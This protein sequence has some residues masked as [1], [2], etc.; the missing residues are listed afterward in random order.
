MGQAPTPAQ[1]RS[2]RQASGLTQKASAQLIWATES[3]WQKYELGKRRMKPV[4]FFA[5]LVRVGL[6][7]P[8]PVV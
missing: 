7:E 1:V 6:M 4:V 5:F 8:Y 2:A 3:A